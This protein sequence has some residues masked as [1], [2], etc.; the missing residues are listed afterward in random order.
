MAEHYG[1]KIEG[2]HK[3]DLFLIEGLPE[4]GRK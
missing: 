4:S 2:P 3:D 1:V